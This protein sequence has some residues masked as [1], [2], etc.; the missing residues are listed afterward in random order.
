MKSLLNVLRSTVAIL[1]GYVPLLGNAA[2]LRLQ[3][4]ARWQLE[5]PDLSDTLA[6]MGSGQRQPARLTV[7]MPLNYSPAGTFPLFVFLNGGD[8]GRGDTLPLDQK[9]VGS[10]DFICVN[11]PLFKRALDKDRGA[12]ITVDDFE[13]VSR[14]YHAMLQK[15]LDIVP[16]VT[17]ERSAFGGFSNGAHAIALLLAGHDEFILGH[18]RAFYFVDGGSPLAANALGDPALKAC[19]FLL[20]RGDQPKNDPE[21]IAYTDLTNALKISAKTHGLKFSVITMRDTGHDLSQE[22]QQILGKWIRGEDVAR[23]GEK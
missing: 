13:T 8:G 19:R 15:L 1:I 2:D 12:L 23:A 18:F 3:P 10:N 17:T 16:N 20:M 21:R 6:T 22:Y 11:L 4:E 9:T 5:F 7:R 14:A